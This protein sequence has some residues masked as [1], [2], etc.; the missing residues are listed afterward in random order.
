MLLELGMRDTVS[1][2]CT[3]MVHLAIVRSIGERYG[4]PEMH[5]NG[6]PGRLS[7]SRGLLV[8]MKWQ[9]RDAPDWCTWQMLVLLGMN[10]L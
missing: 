1:Q 10:V 5:P 4:K 9:A 8:K 6:T 7:L 3:R 2:R